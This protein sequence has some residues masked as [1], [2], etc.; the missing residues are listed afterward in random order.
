MSRA[1]RAF[2]YKLEVFRRHEY[3]GRG[4]WVSI[5]VPREIPLAKSAEN[6]YLKR[7][8]RHLLLTDTGAGTAR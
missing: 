3:G 1:S 4:L 2:S 6:R 7:E 8:P 5:S